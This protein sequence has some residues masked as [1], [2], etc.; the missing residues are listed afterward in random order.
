MFLDGKGR[1]ARKAGHLLTDRLAKCGSL[2]VSHPYGTLR[3]VTGTNLPL[4]IDS[5]VEA[6]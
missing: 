4:T 1:P 3:P 6:Y 2:D 5:D